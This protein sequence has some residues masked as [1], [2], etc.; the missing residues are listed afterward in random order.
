MTSAALLILAGFVGAFLNTVASS[1]SAVTLPI[2]IAV[3]VEPVVANASNRVPIV[4]GCAIAAWRFHRAGHLLWRDGIRFAV[5][6]VLGAILG[7]LLASMIGDANTT[8]LVTIAV[9]FAFVLLLANPARWLAAD[10]TVQPP[11]R[12]PLIMLLMGLVGAWAGLIAVDSGA[13]ALAVLV[14]VAHFAIREANGIKVVALGAAALV[15]V[16]VFWDRGEI[17]WHIASLLAVGSVAGALLGARLA[18]GPHAAKWVFRL[19]LLVLVIEAVR[20]VFTLSAQAALP[21]LHG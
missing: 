19:L 1:G 8:A 20:L 4:I 15:S 3:G 21:G 10:R 6:A 9:A 12:G 18:L 7:A 14:L 13:Y 16:L 5:P 11:N 2:L 17:D